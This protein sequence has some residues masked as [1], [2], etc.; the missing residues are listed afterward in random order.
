MPTSFRGEGF[1]GADEEP[2]RRADLTTVR[3][4][5]WKSVLQGV[6]ASARPGTDYWEFHKD[7]KWRQWKSNSGGKFKRLRLVSMA[8]SDLGKK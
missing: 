2:S 5:G 4:E 6:R 8:E 1:L 7:T 3:D